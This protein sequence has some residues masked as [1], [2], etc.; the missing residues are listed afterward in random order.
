[1]DVILDLVFNHTGESDIF[2]R[3]L[4]FRGLADNAYYR[5]AADGSLVNDTGCGNMVACDH[6]MMR[7]MILD[8]LRHFV[9]HA[10]VDGFRFDLAPVLGRTAEGFSAQADLLREIATDPLLADRILIAEPWDI[11]PGG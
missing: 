11:G 2:G 4:S 3:T 6:P 1:M 9:R 5:H 10:G 8:T 7:R